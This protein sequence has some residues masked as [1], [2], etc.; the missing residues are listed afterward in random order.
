MV[1]TMPKWSLEPNEVK[2]ETQGYQEL[3][4]AYI[5]K[6][7]QGRKKRKDIQYLQKWKISS[8]HLWEKVY[9]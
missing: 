9:N 3:D 1:N 7:Y 2:N 4:W 6:T 5:F 8:V